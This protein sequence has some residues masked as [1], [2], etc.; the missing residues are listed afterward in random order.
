MTYIFTAPQLAGVIQQA[1]KTDDPLVLENVTFLA[2]LFYQD[3]KDDI[4]ELTDQPWPE[5]LAETTF[6]AYNYGAYEQTIRTKIDE[7]PQDFVLS[8]ITVKQIMIIQ[9]LLASILEQCHER[10]VFEIIGN[11]LERDEWYKAH[12]SDSKEIMI[13]IK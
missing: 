13:N 3:C 11:A 10:T 1:L 12:N 8:T 9:Q 4:K 5:R 2:E 6:E 7:L